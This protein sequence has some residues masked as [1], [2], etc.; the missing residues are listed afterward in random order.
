[1]TLTPLSERYRLATRQTL[2]GWVRIS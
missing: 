2:W 1:M